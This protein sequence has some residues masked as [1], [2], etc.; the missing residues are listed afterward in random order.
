MVIK[1]HSIEVAVR[2]LKDRLSE[3]LHKPEA[4]E[5][6]DVTSHG[7]PI[8]RIMPVEQPRPAFASEALDCVL[9][10]G[11]VQETAGRSAGL[12]Y[13]CR[14]LRPASRSLAT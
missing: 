13:R 11:S 14:P 1:G 9:S 3:L 10:P 6:I 4:G 5:E 8:E 7:R 2:E 12:V